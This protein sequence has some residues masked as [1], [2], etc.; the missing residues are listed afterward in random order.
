MD[1]ARILLAAAL[2][3]VLLLVA[4]ACFAAD[5]EAIQLPSPRRSGAVAVEEA[6]AR[7]RS[8]R[9]FRP[10]ALTVE[11]L[12]QVLWCAQGLTG[13]DGRKRAVPSAGA[14]YP[15]RLYAVVG[16]ATCGRIPA[17]VYLYRPDEHALEQHA[18]GDVRNELAA[19]ALHQDF[20]AAAPLVLVLTADYPRTTGRYGQRGIRYVHMEAGHAGQNVHLQSEALGL[21][22][23]MIGAFD[24]E[25]VRKVLSLPAEE[26]PLY[27]MPVGYPE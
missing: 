4:L 19:A 9:A 18:S 1:V 2:P 20:I 22:T 14:T 10:E 6:V 7:R 12:S 27:I 5:G 16:N 21:G 8:R 15:L 25:A 24:D 3:A 17:A 23:C 11:Q 13:S 26:P